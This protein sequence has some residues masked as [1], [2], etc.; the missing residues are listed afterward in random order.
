[1][2]KVTII[3]G[4][5]G[6]KALLEILKDDKSI[7]VVAIVDNNEKPKIS[8][9]AKKLK[10]PVHKDYKTFLKDADIDLIVNVT[11]NPKVA[12]DLEKIR[13]P[14]AEV[15]GGISAKFLWDLIEQRRKVREQVEMRL[16]EHK[17]LNELGVRLS[18]H[19]KL[20]EIFLAIVDKALE[21]TKLPAGS[22]VI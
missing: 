13:P 22:L 1:M 21:L 2:A 5:Q 19:V 7:D 20:K 3:G 12:K 11:G 10:I 18:R 15:I 6:G 17:V 8:S 14:K 9:L 4:G 16:Q